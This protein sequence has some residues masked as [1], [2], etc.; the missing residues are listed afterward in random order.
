MPPKRETVASARS[1]YEVEKRWVKR[2]VDACEKQL[3]ICV[4]DDAVMT[5]ALE[6]DVK[7]TLESATD[8]AKQFE[9]YAADLHRC[10]TKEPPSEET[11]KAMQSLQDEID[12]HLGNLESAKA[13]LLTAYG[14]LKT[15]TLEAAKAHAAALAGPGGGG[16][17]G[18]GP[19]P[20]E[21]L[22]PPML[23]ETD[24]PQTLAAY[25]K[26]LP[27][28]FASSGFN[29]NDWD[30]QIAFWYMTMSDSLRRRMAALVDTDLPI[31][32]P[33]EGGDCCMKRLKDEFEKLYPIFDR[34][35]D[36]YN[37][38]QTPGQ[39]FSDFCNTL[40]VIGN[41][42]DLAGMGIDDQYVVRYMTGT[43]DPELR[44]EFLKLPNP[45]KASVRELGERLE[46]V[47]V[48]TKRLAGDAGAG[49]NQT[50]SQSRN[51][52]GTGGGKKSGGGG[53]RQGG[54]EKRDDDGK[55]SDGKKSGENTRNG[56]PAPNK[57]RCPHCG[58]KIAADK[59]GQ[60]IEACPARTGKCDECG[61]DGSAKNDGHY[62]P[63]CPSLKNKK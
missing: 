14:K 49:A 54:G 11:D 46:S 37:Y 12:V 28:Y 21:A 48:T 42:S 50:S 36:F 19:R 47:R 40:E 13:D 2:R 61:Y 59:I 10:L 35:L 34:R 32:A 44:K 29:D 27:A 15:K 56:N 20:I 45:T 41:T 25:S 22:K 4:A 30:V 39:S 63:Q 8:T 5:Q 52:G 3:A 53:G 60:H 18:K 57:E 9:T 51:R 24:S 6:E 58:W 26:L 33:V 16:G 55:K 38:G 7:K 31:F 43:C 1:F 23:E 17:G 62:R